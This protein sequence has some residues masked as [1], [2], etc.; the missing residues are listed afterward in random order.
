MEF[1]GLFNKS[2]NIMVV[3]V[4]TTR[5]GK[6][7]KQHLFDVSF[8]IYSQETGIIGTAGY[9]IQENQNRVPYYVDRITRYTQY[10]EQGNYAVATFSQVMDSIAKV[11]EKY[12]VRYVTAYNASFDWGQIQKACELFGASY[13]FT[14]VAKFDIMTAF[15]ETIGRRN[16]YHKFCQDNGFLTEAGRCQIKAEVAYRYLVN[17]PQFVEEHTGYADSIIECYILERVLKQRKR[18]TKRILNAGTASRIA[19]KLQAV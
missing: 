2:V 3:D 5:P 14:N 6:D 4:E 8:S 11:I 12:D 15:A 10:V 7:K 16:T 13:P 1:K 9:I 18:L 17:N 19:N